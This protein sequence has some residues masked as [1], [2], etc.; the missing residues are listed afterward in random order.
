MVPLGQGFRGEMKRFWDVKV[1]WSRRTLRRVVVV[2]RH[3]S[4]G[5]FFLD[6]M[7]H[8]L[9]DDTRVARRVLT[10][11]HVMIEMSHFL[12]DWILRKVKGIEM[13]NVSISNCVPHAFIFPLR[14]DSWRL[15]K[16]N[17]RIFCLW[18]LSRSHQ[19]CNTKCIQTISAL[20]RTF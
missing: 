9:G 20:D 15:L 12:N 3:V 18:S 16:F 5:V 19:P 8:Y 10:C 13:A 6:V 1:N 2:T 7:E 17:F 14:M 11:A 4:M